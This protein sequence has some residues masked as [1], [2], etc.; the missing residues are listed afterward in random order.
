MAGGFKIT[1]RF[2]KELISHLPKS[3]RF[4]CH[5]GAGYDQIDIEPCTEQSKMFD[6]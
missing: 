2:D 3:V 1:G 4:I 6:L 5:N